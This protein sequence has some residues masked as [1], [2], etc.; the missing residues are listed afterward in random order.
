MVSRRVKRVTIFASPFFLTG[1]LVFL[2]L[3]RLAFF[4]KFKN[5]WNIVFSVDLIFMASIVVV[6]ALYFMAR[7]RNV[8]WEIVSEPK[9]PSDMLGDIF[10]GGTVGLTLA[11]LMVHGLFSAF[12]M[13]E[14]NAFDSVDSKINELRYSLVS[15]DEEATSMTIL[16]LILFYVAHVALNE[17]LFSS[18]ILSGL[19][20]KR[21]QYGIEA[22]FRADVLKANIVSSAAFA[23]LHVFVWS[24]THDIGYFL[25]AFFVNFIIFNPLFLW[26]G[27]F[28]AIA[29]HGMYD[30]A[31]DIMTR[32]GQYALLGGVVKFLFVVGVTLLILKILV[33]R[34]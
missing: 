34:G 25:S 10:I 1:L 17:R 21:I 12:G 27:I 31:V 2:V 8:I 23:L 16:F 20:K 33:R 18:T 4:H 26:R 11:Y 28:A 29:A 32:T 3:E 15:E 6:G 22:L 13:P 5:V 24:L 19:S 30:A 9:S 7:G 14:F